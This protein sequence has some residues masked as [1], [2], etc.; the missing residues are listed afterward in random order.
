MDP[1]T[2]AALAALSGAGVRITAV[3]CRHLGL[4]WR[5]REEDARGRVVETLARVLPEGGRF[6]EV[7][8]DGSS[9]TL[10]IPRRPVRRGYGTGE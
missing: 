9:V 10:T 1:L 8:S 6:R 3:V 7:R 5:S 2:A 4:R